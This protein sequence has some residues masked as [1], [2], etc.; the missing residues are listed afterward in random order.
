MSVSSALIFP[1]STEDPVDR[2][3]VRAESPS[4]PGA[5]DGSNAENPPVQSAPAELSSPEDEVN[6]QWNTSDQIV[7]YQFVNQ[8]GSLILQVPSEQMLNLASQITQEL[9]QEAA[10]KATLAVTGG[11]DNGS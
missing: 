1:P 9:A 10:P 11:K 4:I 6:V 2:G 3:S 8:Q 7:V 5:G